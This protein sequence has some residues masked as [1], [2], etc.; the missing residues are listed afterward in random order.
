M[1][2]VDSSRSVKIAAQTF[3]SV[4]AISINRISPSEVLAFSVIPL[5]SF[6]RLFASS[7]EIP[8]FSLFLSLLS[9][10]HSNFIHKIVPFPYL[11]VN[12]KCH[13]EITLV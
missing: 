2:R 7:N 5:G 13:I 3:P 10:S 12:A 4:P 1:I 11:F 6:H 8:C 9:G